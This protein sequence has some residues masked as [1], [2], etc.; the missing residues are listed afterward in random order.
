MKQIRG[1]RHTTVV[2]TP[3][4]H[5]HIMESVNDFFSLPLNSSMY[6]ILGLEKKKKHR[7]SDQE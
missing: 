7:G 2:R 3:Q 1:G 6:I 5:G 4:S